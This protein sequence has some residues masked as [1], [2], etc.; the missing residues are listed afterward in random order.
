MIQILTLVN[1]E[2]I[3]GE[4]NLFDGSYQITDPFYIIDALNEQGILG[5]KM[6]DVLTFSSISD[7]TILSTHVIYSFPASE[8][9]ENYYREVVKMSHDYRSDD[10]INKAL[11][12]MKK[13][14]DQYKELLDK[15]KKN[16][17][18]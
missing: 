16:K 9:I 10:I 7:I 2:Q 17:L 4:T 13:A 3:I 11:I 18:N 6:T 5:T 1:G 14:N 12:D 8:S 15:V